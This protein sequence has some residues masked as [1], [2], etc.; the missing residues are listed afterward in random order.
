MHDDKSACERRA[1]EVAL[2]RYGL[3]SDLLRPDDGDASLTLYERLRRKAG[4]S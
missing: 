3:I 1:E 2:F 4:R